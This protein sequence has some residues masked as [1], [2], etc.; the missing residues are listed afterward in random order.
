MLLEKS[1]HVLP[2]CMPNGQ[3]TVPR[4][5]VAEPR[6][7]EPRGYREID[8]G[9]LDRFRC[10]HKWPTTAP[11]GGRTLGNKVRQLVSA[12]DA[13][14]VLVSRRDVDRPEMDVV[15]DDATA[16]CEDDLVAGP[17]LNLRLRHYRAR[18]P[19]RAQQLITDL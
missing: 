7:E 4:R 14:L 6:A 18:S 16:V 12:D 17:V 13:L 10:L 19:I 5:T 15:A 1:K 11:H 9:Q 8:L 2:V 3:L